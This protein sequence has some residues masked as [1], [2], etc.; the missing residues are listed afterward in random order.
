MTSWH[1]HVVW[2]VVLCNVAGRLT[3]TEEGEEKGSGGKTTPE[4][5]Q[6]WTFQSHRGLW[7]TDRDMEAAGCHIIGGTPATVWVKERMDGWVDGWIGR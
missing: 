2:V 3:G 6:D 4:N 7:K 1:Q 5:G